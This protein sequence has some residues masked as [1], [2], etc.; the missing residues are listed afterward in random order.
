[1]AIIMLC[2]LFIYYTIV[3]GMQI[4]GRKF[5]TIQQQYQHWNISLPCHDRVIGRIGLQYRACK[6]KHVPFSS[7]FFLEQVEEENHE[8]TS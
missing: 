2:Y 8:G 1:V 7:S 4:Y 5:S 3:L 6:N